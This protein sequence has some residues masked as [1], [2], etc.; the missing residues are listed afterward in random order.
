MVIRIRRWCVG[1][2]TGGGQLG[3]LGL[4]AQFGDRLGWLIVVPLIASLSL[5]A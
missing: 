5:W 2:L 4:G 3:L 1:L